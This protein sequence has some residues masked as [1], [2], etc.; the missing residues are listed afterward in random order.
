MSGAGHGGG[1]RKHK[2]EEHLNHEAWAIPYGD[3]ITLLL[4]FFVV[5]YAISSLNEGKYRVM[6]DSLS[7]AFKG[8]PTRESPV[9]LPS[10][11]GNPSASVV[12]MSRPAG[13]G[14]SGGAR[15]QIQES[16]PDLKRIA[17]NVARALAENVMKEEVVVRLHDDWLE[18][19][20]QTD[21]LF[22]SGSA[23]LTPVADGIVKRLG[24]SLA[25]I[26]NPIFVEGHTDNVPINRVIFP[27]NWELSTAR[28]AAVIRILGSGGV[29][30]LQMTAVGFG[31][32][33]PI[34][35]NE[36]PE[37][38]AANRRV[39]LAILR[40]ER[41]GQS[42]Y[43]STPPPPQAPPTSGGASSRVVVPEAAAVSGFRP[44]ATGEAPALPTRP[45][46]GPALPAAGSS[47]P[48]TPTAPST[49][50]GPAR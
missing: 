10:V 28:A 50:T 40:P 25:G 4:A 46:I 16:P 36:T 32:F 44:F 29:S 8:E 48:A 41:A 31:E 5:M 24:S 47:T 6:A 45:P 38:R 17:D 35:E 15:T 27:S 14:T 11:V 9:A 49:A 13:G 18:V 42:L 39:M 34:R 19:E 43:S 7:A 37:G 2:H 30:P 33:R 3:L 1:G 22:P 12:T 23:N 20:I 21:V 26:P